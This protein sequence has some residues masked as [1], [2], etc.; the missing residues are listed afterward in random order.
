MGS[1]SWLNW[2]W[3]VNQ[4]EFIQKENFVQSSQDLIGLVYLPKLEKI[5]IEGNPVMKI[6]HERQKVTKRKKRD[7]EIGS[8]PYLWLVLENLEFDP[9]KIF[10][11]VYGIEIADIKYN[12]QPPTFQVLN[13]RF[14][15]DKPTLQVL[16]KKPVPETRIGK[17]LQEQKK[18]AKLHHVVEEI[19][20]K[21]EMERVRARQLVNFFFNY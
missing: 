16:L 7:I 14:A 11:S 3:L 15:Q 4:K 12:K 8:F 6:T 9:I 19:S 21:D 1:T 17:K 2:E 10:P 20:H 13:S 18:N 5:F